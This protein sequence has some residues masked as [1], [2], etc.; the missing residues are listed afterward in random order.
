V[1]GAGVAG[2]AA[3]W[4][5][6]AGTDGDRP[7]T[8]EVIVLEA[9]GRVG[10]NLQ[11]A[12]FAGREVD[13][14]ADAFLARRPEATQL[15]TE[16]G[17]DDELVPVGASGASIWARHRLRPMPDGLNLGIPTRWWPLAR[18]GIL[19]PTESVRVAWDLVGPHRRTGTAFGD[20]SVGDIVGARLGRPVV[21]R[22]ADPLIG[23]IHAGSAD[24]LS[25]A[26]TFPV[27]IAAS[28]QPGSL[29]RR[30]ALAGRLDR[31]R[32]TDPAGPGFWSLRHSTASLTD[33]LVL[34]LRS[35]GVAIHTD[36]PVD[37]IERTRSGRSGRTRWRFGLGPADMTERSAGPV[38]PLEVDGVILAVPAIE[39]AGLLAGHAP[40][41]SEM[42]GAIRYS[43]VAVVTLSL[44]AGTV[45]APL[46]GTG[47]LVPRTSDVDGRPALIT[48]CT[49]LSR[50]WPHLARPGDELLRVSVGRFGDERHLRLG[51]DELVGAVLAELA[52]LLDVRDEPLDALVTRWDRAFPQ[53]E[54]GHLLRVGRIE[55]SLDTVPGV[56]VAGAALRGVGIPACIA[57][58]RSAA[59][60]VL[61]S[62]EGAPPRAATPARGGDPAI[63]AVVEP[64]EATA[65]V[66]DQDPDT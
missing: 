26:A 45:G 61:A 66:G 53:Y 5:L 33:A 34:G 65:A 37:L 29:M 18:S 50:K 20:R 38:G 7:P 56:A 40:V 64:T 12:A 51:D 43:S 47:F 44:P 42:L 16:L 32:D 31:Q 14:A 21:E 49:Y 41:A 57:S 30:L 2:L 54:V 36:A 19:S 4:E 23:G 10:G 3:A 17:L 22:L 1:V 13:L 59:R 11:S 39:A 46:V 8:V 27:L 35:R 62:W 52:T 15:C 9:S 58:G 55:Q 28:N 25:A 6:V 48:G 63:D 24:M 60:R